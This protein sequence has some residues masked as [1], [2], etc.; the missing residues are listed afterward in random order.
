[1]RS[2]EGD[3]QKKEYDRQTKTR[4]NERV[5]GTCGLELTRGKIELD[6][7]SRNL[8]SYLE[9]KRWVKYS[10]ISYDCSSDSSFVVFAVVFYVRAIFIQCI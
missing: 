9:E 5:N 2:I 10:R 3:K 1:M 7:R 6:R 8:G 4:G